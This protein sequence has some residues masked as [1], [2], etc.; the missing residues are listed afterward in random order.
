MPP[1]TLS[2]HRLLD[3][4]KQR[5]HYS[6][7]QRVVKDTDVAEAFS[8]SV[9]NLRRAVKRERFRFPLDVIWEVS[10]RRYIFTEGGVIVVATILKTPQAVQAHIGMIREL[11]GFNKN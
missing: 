9:A 5:S 1:E 3:R 7:G 2:I 11:C 8:V 6:A 4:L 10:P